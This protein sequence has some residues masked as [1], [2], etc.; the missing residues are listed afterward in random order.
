LS[1]LRQGK[2]LIIKNYKQD[3]APILLVAALTL[4]AVFIATPVL[5]PAI[6]SHPGGTT[7]EVEGGAAFTLSHRLRW[8]EA[9]KGY[10]TVTL[11]WTYGGDQSW[12]FTFVEASAYFVTGPYAGQSI[13]ARVDIDDDGSMVTM[14]VGA[15][16]GDPR[17]GEF[18]VDITFRAS[19]TDGTPH[20]PGDH[21]I[22]YSRIRCNEQ[23]PVDL[24]PDNVTIRV[25][26]GVARV[27]VSISPSYQSGSPKEILKYTITVKNLGD[28]EDTYT[29]SVTD[30]AGWGPTVSPLSLKIAAGQFATSTLSVFVPSNA[31]PCTRDNITVVAVSQENAKVNASSTCV[32]HATSAIK[33]VEIYISPRSQSG[34]PGAVVQYT[35]SVRNCGDVEDTFTFQIFDA[36][37]WSPHI[38]PTSLTIA[39]GKVGSATLKLIVPS[40]S[41]EG[42][43]TT[44]TVT[45]TSEIDPM[46]SASDTC[47]V[48][49]RLAPPSPLATVAALITIMALAA[50]CVLYTIRK[51]RRRVKK[52][53]TVLRG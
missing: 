51:H 49:V 40:D 7:V 5:A 36:T 38:E 37:N 8:D 30:D 19:G 32:A 52:G 26:T 34:T 44:V 41:S 31:L 21:P 47:E 15:Y 42:D 13:E 10:Y 46:V 39:A 1:E 24:V 12:N 18:N 50:A 9:A 33:K 22:S 16:A 17:D 48:I 3:L 45:A 4:W 29:L 25:F 20:R 6:I 27:E 53:P 23:T 2:Q 35:V 28:F 14:T 43:S 11:Y